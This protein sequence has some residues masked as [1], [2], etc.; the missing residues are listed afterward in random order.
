MADKGRRVEYMPLTQ[1]EAALRNP[2][3]HAEAE[4]R[5]SIDRFGLAELPLL[6]ERTG[7]LVA[8]HG[9]LDQVAAMRTDGQDP[10]DGVRL[11]QNGEWL[12]P[13]VRGWASRSDAEAD[14][15]LVASNKLTIRG[16][17]DTEGLVDLLT[18]LGAADAELLKL[19]GFRED[20]LAD[21]VAGQEVPD[22]DDFKNFDDV[23]KGAGDGPPKPVTCPDCGLEFVPEGK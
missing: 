22:L 12:V 20:E 1:V 23:D 9:R 13:I 8:G 5:A 6:D 11:A 2:K 16:G 14:S 10:P 21:L 19:T 18:E 17:W 7:R 4:I 3:L 15:Y